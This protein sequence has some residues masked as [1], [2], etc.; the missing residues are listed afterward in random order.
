VQQKLS[1]DQPGSRKPPR[2]ISHVCA[3]AYLS[4]RT[5]YSSSASHPHSSPSRY[6]PA[7]QIIV[8][9]RRRPQR[10]P[11]NRAC[12]IA[13]ATA[14]RSEVSAHF[15]DGDCQHQVIAIDTYSRTLSSKA[16]APDGYKAPSKFC[17]QTAG[18]P[19]KNDSV[20]A[21]PCGRRIRSHICKQT[22]ADDSPPRSSQSFPR[23]ERSR[24]VNYII[25]D[26][27][28][29]ERNIAT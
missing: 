10:A 1:R 24:A 26:Y 18:F 9:P 8:L 17:P 14:L 27:T 16:A 25:A 2:R 21:A 13:F 22:R 29:H 15:R 4:T 3:S 5:R 6:A 20:S 19:Q 23:P 11:E 12:S 7:Q 28:L